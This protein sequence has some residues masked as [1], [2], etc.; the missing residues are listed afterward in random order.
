MIKITEDILKKMADTIVQQVHPA[1]ILVFGSH[2][3]NSANSDSDVDLLIVE[4]QPFGNGRSRRSEIKRVRNALSAFKIPKVILVYSVDEVEKWR[5]SINH[6]V[7]K[8]YK[9]GK[10]LY[11]QH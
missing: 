11:E 2:A 1:Q 9:Y 6:V 4:S 3:S 8:A 5:N 7:A 10:V